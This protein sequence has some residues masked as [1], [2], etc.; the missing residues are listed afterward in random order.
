MVAAIIAYSSSAS[1]TN[2]SITNNK[3]C[4]R[5]TAMAIIQSYRV[6]NM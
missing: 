1:T 2:I 5:M 4:N 3:M 6:I